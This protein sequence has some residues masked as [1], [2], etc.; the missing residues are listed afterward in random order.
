MLRKNFIALNTY[1]RKEKRSKINNLCFYYAKLLK[2]EQIKPKVSRRK[3]IRIAINEIKN[4]REN[5]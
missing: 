5:Q 2:E 3:N 4:I 1:F